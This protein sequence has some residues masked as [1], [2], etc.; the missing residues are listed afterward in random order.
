MFS[1]SK[2]KEDNQPN[3]RFSAIFKSQIIKWKENKKMVR[4]D[5]RA[6]K[7]WNKKVI[8]L[9]I[10]AGGLERLFQRF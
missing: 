8:V 9:P 1:E 3:N 4:F 5:K 7:M 10:I 6:E 2:Q